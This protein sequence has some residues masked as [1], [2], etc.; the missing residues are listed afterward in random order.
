M[1]SDLPLE[2][3]AQRVADLGRVLFLCAVTDEDARLHGDAEKSLENQ[4]GSEL[5]IRGCGSSMYRSLC[6]YP[7]LD[8]SAAS[9]AKAGATVRRQVDIPIQIGAER[10]SGSN[11]RITQRSRRALLPHDTSSLPGLCPRKKSG[12]L[13]IRISRSRRD[14]VQKR[15]Y[16]TASFTSYCVFQ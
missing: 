5:H 12:C 11:T 3:R 14:P 4:P 1:W 2:R 15:W 16:C 7:S 8:E 10:R 9:C 13:V 6:E